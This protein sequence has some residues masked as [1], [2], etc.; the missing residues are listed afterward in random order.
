MSHNKDIKTFKI[1]TG[2]SYKESRQILKLTSW[3]LEKALFITLVNKDEITNILQPLTKSFSD[4]GELL[5]RSVDATAE[6][7]NLFID[8]LRGG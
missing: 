8:R 5:K 4:L 1:I 7:I 2:K 3:N 6:L